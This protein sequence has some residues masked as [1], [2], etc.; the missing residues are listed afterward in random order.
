MSKPIHCDDEPRTVETEDG[1][2]DIIT[3]K[4]EP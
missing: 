3:P 2:V 4:G 1:G